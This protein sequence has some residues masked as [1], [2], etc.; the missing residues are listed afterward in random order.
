M[1]EICRIIETN[2]SG[3][4]VEE[5]RKIFISSIVDN[6][7]F[8]ARENQFEIGDDIIDNINQKCLEAI[9]FSKKETPKR[10]TAVKAPVAKDASG[11]QES[12]MSAEWSAGQCSKKY[13]RKPNDGMYCAKPA[14][15]DMAYCKSHQRNASKA[16]ATDTVVKARGTPGINPAAPKKPTTPMKG[17]P[18]GFNVQA[19]KPKVQYRVFDE[20]NFIFVEESTGICFHRPDGNHEEGGAFGRMVRIGSNA[21]IIPLTGDDREKI[22]VLKMKELPDF[23]YTIPNHLKNASKPSAPEDFSE[24][25]KANIAPSFKSSRV[26][27]KVKSEEDDEPESKPESDHEETE[28]ESQED[29]E[30][31]VDEDAEEEAE[32]DPEPTPAPVEKKAAPIIRRAAG[33]TSSGVGASRM[34]AAKPQTST[35]QPI[36]K[37]SATRLQTN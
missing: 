18:V 15:K 2:I 28:T 20:E 29:K 21:K 11:A 6:F 16:K 37:V 10:K 12:T 31:Q 23:S 30:T 26:T 8:K 5:I 36:R 7:V 9:D 35:S 19:P 32:E 34:A 27:Q 3:I 25:K 1:E 17:V 4:E 33:I 14:E 22:K 13:T 24:D